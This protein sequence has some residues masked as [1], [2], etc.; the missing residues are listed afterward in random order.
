MSRHRMPHTFSPLDIPSC[1]WWIEA[2]RGITLVSGNVSVAADQ[3]THGRNYVQGTNTYRPIY[4]TNMIGGHPAIVSGAGLYL[5]T[6]TVSGM[7][8][9][10]AFSRFTLF[11]ASTTT[12]QQAI[13]GTNLR[14]IEC[15]IVTG[16]IEFLLKDN[17]GALQYLFHCAF[18]STAPQVMSLLYDGSQGTNAA[19][20]RLY[21]N[22]VQQN[23][24]FDVNVPGQL[25]TISICDLGPWAV[26]PICFLG[27][28][29]LDVFYPTVVKETQR[30]QIE[31]AYGSKYGIAVA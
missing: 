9:L 5:A 14:T 20:L 17:A 25:Y 21:L 31:R 24:I 4:A 11:K 16:G 19:R 7:D 13:F 12:T 1:A 2:D 28:L 10:T 15:Q 22:G 26:V 8:N 3:T 27:D 29:A 6:G 23:L 30:H 18:T